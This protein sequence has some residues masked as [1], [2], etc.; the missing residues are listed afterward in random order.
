MVRSYAPAVLLAFIAAVCFERWWSTR[1]RSAAV[2]Y[3]VCAP[4][5]LWF[6]LSVAP[7]VAAP[8]VYGAIRTALDSTDR[9]RRLR[10]LAV[11]GATA[12]AGVALFL[13]PALDS[14][15][16]L[17]EVHGRGGLPSAETWL[18]VLRMHSG[19]AQPL[20]SALVV[21]GLL[22]GI[23][24]SWRCDRDW[25]GY[26]ASLALLHLAGLIALGP[27]Q[28]DNPIVINRYGLVALPFGLALTARGLAEPL[29]PVPTRLQRIGIVGLLAAI[30]GTGP[31]ATTTFARTS[32]ATASTFAYFV[33]DGN[34]VVLRDVPEFY[35]TLALA[36]DEQPVIEYP[37]SNLA[38]HAIDAYQKHHG[39]PVL[40]A[41]PW[42]SLDDERLALRQTLPAR[43]A[44]Y[45]DSHARWLIVHQD[46]QREERRIRT[47]DPNHWMRLEDR[48][49]IWRP[50]QTAGPKTTRLLE[51]RFGEADHRS[52][53]LAVW[54]LDRLR[55]GR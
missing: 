24:L 8:M 1:R 25:L 22:R 23:V 42:K 3:I 40:M 32:F 33:R 28:L 43:V 6:N 10:E 55:A 41:A 36:E 11:L 50:L 18:E 2:G 16:T 15:S 26:V 12:L 7:F 34:E 31:F 52:D 48:P 20:V 27:D 30:V 38:T 4:L 21:L 17:S 14:F 53:Q 9:L 45:L 51:R 5:A 39:Q 13:L 54:D 29:S 35:R 49:R 47:S 44:R 19:S 37:W 46:L